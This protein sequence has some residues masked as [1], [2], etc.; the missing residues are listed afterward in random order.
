MPACLHFFRN[1]IKSFSLL[2]A[3]LLGVSLVACEQSPNPQNSSVSDGTMSSPLP[4]ELAEYGIN[5]NNLLV[6]IIVDG[7]AVNTRLCT[8]LRVSTDGTSTSFSC[9]VDL[10]IGPHSLAINFFILDG[11]Y[12]KVEIAT[13]SP[14]D[15]D[16]D[17]SQP[18]P[19]PFGTATYDYSID[20]DKDGISNFDELVNG[21]DPSVYN[22]SLISVSDSIA[23][24][25]DKLLAFSNTIINNSRS[26]TIT[27]TNDGNNALT[28]GNIGDSDALAVPFSIT[29]DN[30]SAQSIAVAASCSIT[31][32]FS[33]ISAADF[34]DS[35][36][37]PTNASNVPPGSPLIINVTGTGDPQPIPNISISDSISP[38][39]DKTLSFADSK[40]GTVVTGTV[41]VVNSGTATLTLG[42]VGGSNPLAAPFAKTTDTCSNA[43]LAP[44]SGCS[45][46]ITYSPTA[47]GSLSDSFD[48]PSN[49]PDQPSVLFTVSGYSYRCRILS[50]ARTSSATA[51]NPDGVGQLFAPC[52]NGKITTIAVDVLSKTSIKIA[53]VLGIQDTAPLTTVLP[54]TQNVTLVPGANIIKLKTP[55]TISTKVATYAF[56]IQPPTGTSISLWLGPAPIKTAGGAVIISGKTFTPVVPDSNLEFLINVE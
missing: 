28:I 7:D 38:A 16:I 4:I 18:T 47:S 34:V 55:Y 2:Y 53:A 40:I 23:P 46:T 14:I 43:S 20:T 54:Y 17:A 33:P 3:I 37:I 44:N 1:N 15:V 8:N 51:T 9:S 35:F 50:T 42:S 45:L 41:T 36:N 6:Y 13:S 21:W 56:G 39:T 27:F 22:T 48:I 32:V 25:N 10:P 11:V 24:N 29:N 12:G 31:V 49:D 26:A 19:A 52:D 5:D 30:C